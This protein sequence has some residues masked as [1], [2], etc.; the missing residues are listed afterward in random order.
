MENHPEKSVWYTGRIQSQKIAQIYPSGHLC[1]C[2]WLLR[3]VQ[4]Q[5]KMKELT[6]LL[7]ILNH[8]HEEAVQGVGGD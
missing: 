2:S 5:V 1:P 4:V 7:Q 3:E 8:I 6:D